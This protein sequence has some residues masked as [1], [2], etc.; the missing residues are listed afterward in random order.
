MG[1]VKRLPVTEY[2]AQH[3]GGRGVTAHKTKEEDFVEKMFV[4]STHDDLLFFTNFGKVYR[5]KGYEIPEAQRTAR[6]R[7]VINL[8]QISEG[9]KVNAIIPLKETTEGYIAM[10]TRKGLI[11]KTD[12]KEFESIRKTG[13]I[14]ISLNEGDELVSVQF[15][16]GEDEIFI[17]NK[18]GKCIRFYEGLDQEKGTYGLKPIGRDTQGVKAMDLDN[19]ELISMAVV[20]KDLDLITI[21]ENGYGKRSS[22]EDY[23]LQGRA[24]KGIKSG[25]YNEKTGLP[26]YIGF[27]SSDQDILLISDN[28]I[29][30][31][32]K[33]DEISHLGRD[34]QGVIV[35]RVDG[36]VV[37][38]VASV[39]HEDEEEVA[40]VENVAENGEEQV[41]EVT[42]TE[43]STE[44]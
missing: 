38:T 14:A 5:I 4:S 40:S 31:R 30:I 13:K 36:G 12:L 35:M 43:T 42:L 25:V 39:P 22:I 2:K 11:K 44:Q 1:Y 34:T 27:A 24:G 21:T 15:T 41:N 18:K 37:S 7:A 6:G 20:N 3:R 16:T 8:I 17:A 33:V 32:I 9:E 26:S 23:R 28:G 19:D 29:I 10:A